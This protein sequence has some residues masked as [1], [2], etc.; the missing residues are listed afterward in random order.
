MYLV[1]FDEPEMIGTML[2]RS[3]EEVV[4]RL[5]E[6]L[7]A[8]EKG[9]STIITRHGRPVAVLAPVVALGA[10]IGQ[11]PLTPWQGSGRGLWG[12]DSARTFSRLRDEWSR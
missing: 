9:H 6:L 2:R 4:Q 7:D 1:L 11:Q 3:T 12:G 10:G 8:A 5:P